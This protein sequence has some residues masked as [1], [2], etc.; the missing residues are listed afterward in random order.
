MEPTL[1]TTA[2]QG[3]G[4][5]N[6]KRSLSPQRRWNAA[7]KEYFAARMRAKYRADEAFRKMHIARVIKSRQTR[8]ASPNNDTVQTPLQPINR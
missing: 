6:T 8:L 2:P 1:P 7:H 4:V 5:Q 3:N